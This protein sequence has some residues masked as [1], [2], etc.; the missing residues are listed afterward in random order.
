MRVIEFGDEIG[1]RTGLKKKLCAAVIREFIGML[2]AEFERGEDVRITHF[3]TF[4]VRDR[5][6]RW[7]RNPK[8]GGFSKIKARR[9]VSFKPSARLVR[10]LKSGA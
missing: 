8:T 6:A 2:E 10:K 7:M 9:S 5:P 3:G 4:H 1:R